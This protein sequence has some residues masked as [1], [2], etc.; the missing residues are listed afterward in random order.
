LKSSATGSRSECRSAQPYQPT[1]AILGREPG[2]D[3][4]AGLSADDRNAI[5]EILSASLPEVFGP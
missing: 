5:R 2:S 3:D 4:Y 1:G